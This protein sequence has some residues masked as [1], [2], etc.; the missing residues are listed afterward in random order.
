MSGIQFE[1]YTPKPLAASGLVQSG[2]G[3]M[4]GILV[5]TSTALTIKVW[6]SLTAT[7]TVILETT[8]ALTA[9]Q[10]L[11][12]PAAFSVGCFITIGGSGTFTAFTA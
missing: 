11:R 2:P 4:G 5:G 8:A 7:G 9:G 10:F 1:A 6:D 12:I 3:V